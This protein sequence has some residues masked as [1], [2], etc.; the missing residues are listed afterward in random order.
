MAHTFEV[1]QELKGQGAMD[2]ADAWLGAN[3]A[4]KWSVKFLGMAEEKDL[5]TGAVEPIIKVR[6]LFGRRE[7][8]Q[9]FKREFIEG[10]PPLARSTGKATTAPRKGLLRRVLGL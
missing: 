3:A 2:K 10:K 6:L 9:R 4:G 5:K 7:D 1:E 8:L